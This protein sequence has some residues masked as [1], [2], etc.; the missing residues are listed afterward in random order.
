MEINLKTLKENGAFV[1]LPVKKHIE[2]QQ[3]DD[4]GNA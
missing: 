1:G 4:D 3:F 2:W